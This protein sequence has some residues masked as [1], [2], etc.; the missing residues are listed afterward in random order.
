M[1]AGALATIKAL[2][3]GFFPVNLVFA[4]ATAVATG[5]QV[6]MIKRQPEPTF[7]SGGMWRNAGVLRGA[8][9]KEGGIDMIDNKTGQK[10]AEVENKEAYIVSSP[11]TDY[12][13]DTLDEII[14]QSLTG[15]P[16]PLRRRGNK[17]RYQMGGA[18][19]PEGERPFWEK[20]FY[21]EGRA[22]YE[23]EE[24]SGG[25]SSNESSYSSGGSGDG[26]LNVD[27]AKAA[28][29][30][31]KQQGENQL[32]LLEEIARNTKEAIEATKGITPSI[33]ETTQA[34]RGVEGAVR[35]QD[36]S[37]R[38][39]NIVNAISNLGAK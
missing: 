25:Y 5:I 4:A 39:D 28:G 34:V 24:S 19:K 2:A 30:A 33:N 23:E 6:A 8:S 18:F 32:K 17:R 16:A 26:G 12:H 27:E 35:G 22:A 10:V 13:K 1:I 36:Q 7:A 14:N 38:L 37:W 20:N 11:V 21:Q 9:H 29:E 3:S 15:R 31:A